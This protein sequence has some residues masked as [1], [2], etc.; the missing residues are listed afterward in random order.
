M[1]AAT[2]GP[3]IVGL[4][5]RLDRRLRL[6]PFPSARDG[7]KFL[8]YA[9]TGALLVPLLG[10]WAWP[11]FLA[12]GFAV[13]VWQPDGKP[14]DVRFAEWLAWRGRMRRAEPTGRAP[15]DLRL[16]GPY[17]RLRGGRLVA[18][19]ACDGTPTAFL[20]ADELRVRFETFRA[21]WRSLDGGMVLLATGTP[22]PQ[23]Q[24]VPSIPPEGRGDHAAAQAYGDLVR[25][26]IARRLRRTVYVALWSDAAGVEG[27]ERLEARVRAVLERL[28]QLGT[29]PTRLSDRSLAQ[30]ASA[31]GWT[32]QRARP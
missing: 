23:D 10:V 26:L 20:P 16:R 2:E 13:S 29:R 18:V 11:P 17:L 8:T 12:A 9:A 5:E 24:Y 3:P 15:E 4:P 28:D 1:A 19:L 14:V 21:L 25:H 27:I 6:G 32:R 22:I 7:L 31:L 30:A